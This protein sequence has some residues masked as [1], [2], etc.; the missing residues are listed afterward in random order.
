MVGLKLVDDQ[1]EASARRQDRSADASEERRSDAPA[2]CTTGRN[3]TVNPA[4]LLGHCVDVQRFVQLGELGGDGL[5]VQ[6][7]DGCLA[8][9]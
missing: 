7:V 9:M 8:I 2:D 6:R 3:R 4:C 5:A 1:R